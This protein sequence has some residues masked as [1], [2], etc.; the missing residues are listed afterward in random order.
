MRLRHGRYA[1]S[2][3]RA[4][5]SSRVP[6]LQEVEDKSPGNCNRP[7]QE[8]G[9]SPMRRNHRL[10]QASQGKSQHQVRGDADGDVGAR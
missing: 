9:Q 3:E 5:S 2:A 4:N 1:Q 10:R 7:A 6:L 8:G